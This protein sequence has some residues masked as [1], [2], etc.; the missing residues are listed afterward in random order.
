MKINFYSYI[1]NYINMKYLLIYKNNIHALTYVIIFSIH[2]YVR[3]QIIF[4][5]M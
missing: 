5:L 3:V 1:C 2:T 4:I